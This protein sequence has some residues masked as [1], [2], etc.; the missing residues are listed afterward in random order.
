[1]ANYKD[2]RCSDCPYRKGK[3][4][5]GTGYEIRKKPLA[6]DLGSK[7]DELIVLQAP[8]VDEWNIGF[9]LQP[10]IKKGGSAGSRVKQS[11]E[12]LG[13]CRQNY[14][15]TNAV[16]CFPGRV[17][18]RDFVPKALA[19]AKCLEWLKEDILSKEYRRIIVFGEVAER[20]T[21]LAIEELNLG[22]DIEVRVATHPTG[23][24][25]RDELDGLWS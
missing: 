9:P 21:K 2:S 6:M 18:R 23:G 25:R 7:T 24:C 11:W 4:L 14:D 8:G 10:T 1:M 16:Q 15:I 17:G 22:R 19:Q 5:Q 13:K 12:R 20:Q 3:H